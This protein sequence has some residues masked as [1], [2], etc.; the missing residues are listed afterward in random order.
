MANTEAEY[1][2]ERVEKNRDTDNL[3]T[4]K[5]GDGNI[6]EE[7]VFDV[8]EYLEKEAKTG[9]NSIARKILKL[10]EYGITDEE[11]ITRYQDKAGTTENENSAESILESVFY[12]LVNYINDIPN[13][14][15]IDFGTAEKNED[16]SIKQSIE[17]GILTEDIF[18][19]SLDKT[20][21]DTLK[22]IANIGRK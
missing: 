10:K 3:I 6:F 2:K 15:Y 13:G 5:K 16:E 18:V 14:I 20:L 9:N 8:L 7:Q 12:D 22:E 11:I 19:E 4:E 17:Y 1:R 21:N